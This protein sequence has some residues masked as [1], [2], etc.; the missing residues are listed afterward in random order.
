MA[1]YIE[2]KGEKCE[3][4]EIVNRSARIKTSKG[5]KIILVPKEQAVAIPETKAEQE[6][7]AEPESSA[8]SL[9]KYVC[10][11]VFFKYLW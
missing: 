9:V 6:T 11:I 10:V 1:K 5:E 4:V 7:K 2:Y 3:V 8:F